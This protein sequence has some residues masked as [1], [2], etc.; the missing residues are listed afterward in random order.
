MSHTEFQSF[1][2]L[3]LCALEANWTSRWGVGKAG[4]AA[5]WLKGVMILSLKKSSIVCSKYSLLNF[6]FSSYLLHKAESFLRS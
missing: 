6:S 2:F 5:G 3:A 4:V 1:V